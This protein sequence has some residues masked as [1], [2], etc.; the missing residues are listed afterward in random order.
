MRNYLGIFLLFISILFAL[1][2][3]IITSII[4][5]D[6]SYLRKNAQLRKHIAA[7]I[8]II[9]VLCDSILLLLL[10]RIIFNRWNF[11]KTA[12]GIFTL[13][14]LCQEIADCALLLI[15][16]SV[17]ASLLGF[18]IRYFLPRLYHNTFCNPHLPLRRRTI[19]FTLS[20]IILSVGISTT[21]YSYNSIYD[22]VINEIGPFNKSLYI[23]EDDAPY[24]Y[25]ELYNNGLFTCRIQDLYLSDDA[26]MLQKWKIPDQSLAG[27]EYCLLSMRSSNFSISRKGNETLF[28]SDGSG[29]ILDQV[30]IPVTAADIS[31][32]RLEDGGPDWK[33][34][35]QTPCATNASARAKTSA[36]VQLS[37][38]GGF[39]SAPF[40]L[41]LNIEEGYDIYYTLDGSIPDENAIRY[42]EPIYIY[43]R[44]SEPNIFRS[45]QRVVLDWK[46]YTPDKTPV[47]KAF[48]IRAVPIAE[49]GS[50]GN[51]V[52]A[53]YMINKE[54]YKDKPVVSLIAD[55]SELFG[56]NGIYMTGIA[57]D[58]LYTEQDIS[59]KD[60]ANFIQSG[61]EHE[62]AAHMEY[63]ADEDTSFRQNVGLRISGGSS[64]LG[65]IKRFSVYAR[66]QYSN[67]NI[68]ESVLFA[69]TITRRVQLRPGYINAVSQLLVSDRNVAIQ[70]SIP[71]YIFVNGEFWEESY[72]LEKYDKFFF[73]EKYGIPEEEVVIFKNYSVNDWDPLDTKLRDVVYDYLEEHDLAIPENYDGFAELVDLQSYID[74][75]CANVYLYNTDFSEDHNAIWWR[76]RNKFN[77]PYTD[78]RWRFAMYDM[79]FVGEG[80]LDT[81]IRGNLF[82]FT[83][84]PLSDHVMYTA[85]K[86]S[87]EFRKQFVLTFM[88][89]VNT[90]FQYQRVVP[91]LNAY[92]PVIDNKEFH[93]FFRERKQYVVPY[94]IDE[95]N[96]TGT[97][98]SITIK[99]TNG[100]TIKL[101][102]I[103]PDLSQGSWTGEYY[104]DYPLT[105]SALPDKGYRFICWEGDISAAEPTIEIVLPKGGI[106]INAV[107]EKV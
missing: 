79:D 50:I 57:Y 31:Y 78:G 20:A 3:Y 5:L 37:H 81:R 41:Y 105:L 12:R 18:G 99:S 70:R 89:M 90:N 51:V 1:L 80:D 25:V 32:S 106:Q 95:F 97:T 13:T 4:A 17:F 77:T 29:R 101:N 27:G 71:I 47:S 69:D 107:F 24:D 23:N 56:D 83:E 103:T 22:I 15:V 88:D 49:D 14:L 65:P 82:T 46:N 100:G 44:S 96:L 64:R 38:E 26:T 74:F 7:S 43:D 10:H 28:L 35:T 45:L 91:I 93:Q 21:F 36:Q 39:Y 94:L 6:T 48:I 104:T 53:T 60:I 68:L 30:H 85:L 54:Q 2:P 98:E 66:N 58:S 55:P 62:I 42:N 87:S 67:G 16:S 84:Y 19:L 75:M 73:Q 102:T 9:T 8:L 11:L 59:N 92:D 34:V 61:R 72:M 86:S 40:H 33:T 52:S 63:Y 76:S